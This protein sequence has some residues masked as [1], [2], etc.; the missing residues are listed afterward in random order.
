MTELTTVL[1]GVLWNRLV[2][3][4]DEAAA[5]LVRTSY[6]IVV[7][8]YHDYCVGVFDR[9][10]NM[11]A[12]STKTTA[13]FIGIMPI[14]MKNF[15]A[16]FPADTLA[17]GDILITNDPWA[18][19]GHLLDIT[20]ATPIWHD[21]AIV[22]FAVCVVHH[23]DMGGRMASVESRDMY[24]E[25]LKIPISKFYRAGVRDDTIIEFLRA[26]VRVSDKVIG[27]VN[28]Q[29]AAINIVSMGIGKMISDYGFTD[30]TALAQRII[31]AS[32]ASMRRQIGR[33]PDG[34]YRNRV[35][36]PPIGRARTP[37]VLNVAVEVRGEEIVI[38][39]AGSSPE[40]DAAI[41][42]TLPMTTS[43]STYPIKVAI[44]P[45]VPN[46]AGCLAPITVIAPEGSAL[47]CR[48][49]AP[50]WGRTI[51]AHN[52]PE[53]IF[54]A[55]AQAMPDRIIAACGSTPLTA[56][57]FNGRKRSGET[58]LS[59]IS[60]MGGF[61]G[62]PVRDGYS[63]LSFPYNTATI[64]A[65][66]TEN[67]TALVYLR[68]ELLPDSAG[69][70]RHRGGFGQEVEIVVPDDDQGPI[71]PITT[72]IRGSSRSPDSSY[73]IYGRKGGGYGR[74]NALTLNGE[75]VPHGG[76]YRMDPGTVL[77][78]ELPGGGGYGD[79]LDRAPEA[80][81]R[82]VRAGLVSP[83]KAREEYGV[84]FDQGGNIDRSATE[85]LRQNRR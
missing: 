21:G 7:R 50:T 25:G 35:D 49:P 77:R 51:I 42:V 34:I 14:V 17:Q 48:P 59:I 8:D 58:F 5:G 46:N 41:N 13:G 23:L 44:D 73:P 33:I 83:D 11:L 65:E 66:V 56:M 71:G 54:G 64:P 37:T 4:V 6:S 36:M 24:E 19:T 68:K 82:D 2:A 1:T 40:I 20:I 69:P 32:E 62:G 47:N 60:H 76:T 52:L 26:N 45:S 78:F 53:L 3:I 84:A 10:G 85:S 81:A 15:L 67:D 72:S 75:S 18:A 39:Y 55:L 63:C 43:Y 28:S 57:Y 12:H 61:G 16:R 31:E 27:D 74:G 38:D 9:D 30:L 29:I 22:G 80:V 70:G 79:P